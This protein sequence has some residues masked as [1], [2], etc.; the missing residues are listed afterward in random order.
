MIKGAQASEVQ[1][2]I[3]HLCS[4]CLHRNLLD[5]DGEEKEKEQ[6]IRVAE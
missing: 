6:A 3:L 5:D 1:S 2:S 4:G